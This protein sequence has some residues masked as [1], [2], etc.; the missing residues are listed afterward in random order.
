MFASRVASEISTVTSLPLTWN[1]FDQAKGN[2]VTAEAWVADGA[3]FSRT[4]ESVI[5][6]WKGGRAVWRGLRFC[7]VGGERNFAAVS[8]KHWVARQTYTF[9]KRMNTIYGDVDGQ[10]LREQQELLDQLAP[11]KEPITQEAWD[12]HRVGNAYFAIA[13]NTFI[14]SGPN[15]DYTPT[16]YIG[17]SSGRRG[18]DPD[19]H[20]QGYKLACVP[21]TRTMWA[22]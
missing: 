11:E 6:G 12:E 16:D 21:R 14:T 10:I 7:Q 9:S 15:N 8:P 13:G 1:A 5:M 19:P 17:K 20:R 22:R 4:R 18:M 3:E 2:D